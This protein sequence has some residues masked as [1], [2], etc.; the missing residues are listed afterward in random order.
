MEFKVK[1]QELLKKIEELIRQGN[2]RRIIIKD[3]NGKTFIEIPLTFGV[4]GVLAAPVVTVI[5]SLAGAVANFT[6]E[7][8]KND[9]IKDADFVEVKED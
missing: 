7:I 9:D 3:S 4:I 5:A 2:V 1:G 8:I 6:I